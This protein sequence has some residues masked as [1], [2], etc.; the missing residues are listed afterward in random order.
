MCD[1]TSAAVGR[2]DWDVAGP[3]RDSQWHVSQLDSRARATQWRLATRRPVHAARLLQGLTTATTSL[4]A[5]VFA[6]LYFS[7]ILNSSRW[8]VDDV[9]KNTESRVVFHTGIKSHLFYK[10]FLKLDRNSQSMHALLDFLTNCA[11]G[12]L[13]GTWTGFHVITVGWHWEEGISYVKKTR[14]LLLGH[15]MFLSSQLQEEENQRVTESRTCLNRSAVC[16]FGWKFL[17]CYSMGALPQ[18]PLHF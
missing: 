18:T 7:F 4:L 6:S 12:L 8:H 11:I 15:G 16:V 10:P 1:V 9:V 14:S 17:F 2:C 13:K 3:C 5:Q